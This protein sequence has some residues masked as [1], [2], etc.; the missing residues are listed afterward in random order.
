MKWKFIIMNTLMA[1]GIVVCGSAEVMAAEETKEKPE[2]II[3]YKIPEGV[4]LAQNSAGNIEEGR[5]EFEEDLQE[6][7]GKRFT[8]A[9]VLALPANV[10]DN[11]SAENL[12]QQNRKVFIVDINL[13]G[14][15]QSEELFQNAFGAQT[16]GIS[17]TIKVH[18][19]ESASDAEDNKIYSY[20]YGQQEYGKGFV[21]IGRTVLA[22]DTDPRTNVKD[23]VKAMM[24][25]ACKLNRQN[26]NKYVNPIAY[27][28]EV[29]RYAG[30]FKRISIMQEKRKNELNARFA[31]FRQ[32][33]Q[34]D[35]NYSS[36]LP[37][38]D[39]YSVEQK[40]AFID[41]LISYGAYREN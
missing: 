8:I 31:K 21:A 4:L 15:G 26:I 32:W 29:D 33:C 1:I 16:I 3:Y 5:T 36:L 23:S 41:T 20:D 35:P 39:N 19:V 11:K 30:N 34:A 10:V 13:E 37:M 28:Y 2:V 6:Y 40:L 27:S 17:P 24:R 38:F 22:A 18:L 14:Q 12:I 9:N 7:Y 25:D